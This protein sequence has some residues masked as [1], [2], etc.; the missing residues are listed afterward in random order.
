MIV[1]F[2]AKLFAIYLSS[3][4]LEVQGSVLLGR[5]HGLLQ[6]MMGE[7]ELAGEP[8]P[9]RGLGL[10]CFVSFAPFW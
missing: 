9:E 5:K 4:E 2:F 7:R 10:H 3:P 6:S 1:F 8:P